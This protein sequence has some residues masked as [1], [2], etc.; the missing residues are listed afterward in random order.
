MADIKRLLNKK[1]WTGRELG[2]IELTNYGGKSR[3]Y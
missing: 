1:S 3:I 2:I